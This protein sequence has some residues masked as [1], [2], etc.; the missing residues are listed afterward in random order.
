MCVCMCFFYFLSYFF[1]LCNLINAC[2]LFIFFSLVTI[3][4]LL[5]LL[6]YLYKTV[7]ILF[8]SY[9]GWRIWHHIHLSF[10]VWL[11]FLWQLQFD[12]FFCFVSMVAISNNSLW[13]SPVMGNKTMILTLFSI[14]YECTKR[15]SLRSIE[16][17]PC[18]TIYIL[19]GWPLNTSFERTIFR[20]F[21]QVYA[22]CISALDSQ[23]LAF[24]CSIVFSLS[25]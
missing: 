17:R 12:G 25:A 3:K 22:G 23:M 14:I 9:L 10:I 5:V 16:M 8:G 15:L 4:C 20:E 18:L 7:L 13:Q 11:E 24:K 21:F 6:F 19:R 2:Y 1:L